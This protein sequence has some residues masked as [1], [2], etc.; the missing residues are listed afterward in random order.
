MKVKYSRSRHNAKQTSFTSPTG[1]RRQCGEEE[2]A[3][4]CTNHD[5]TSGLSCRRPENVSILSSL[6]TKTTTR[7]MSAFNFWRFRQ[8][9]KSC[10]IVLTVFKIWSFVSRWR[11]V[12]IS[13]AEW[14]FVNYAVDIYDFA[15]YLFRKLLK[16]KVCPILWEKTVSFRWQVYSGVFC[17]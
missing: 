10:C 9:I 7:G 6:F 4:Y 17:S 3:E 16:K 11:G 5:A 14:I 8:P 1:V 12:N 13:I 15:L 2:H